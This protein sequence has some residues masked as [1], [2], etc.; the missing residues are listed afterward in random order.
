MRGMFRG[1][2]DPHKSL[3][4]VGGVR[5]SHMTLLC[6]TTAFCTEAL[7]LVDARFGRATSMTWLTSTLGSEF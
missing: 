4:S 6:F 5:A 3:E 2:H 7:H 1:P